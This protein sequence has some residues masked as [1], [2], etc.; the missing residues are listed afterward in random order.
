MFGLKSAPNVN[1][2]T[3]G[4]RVRNR[5]I[6]SLANGGAAWCYVISNMN[7]NRGQIKIKKQSRPQMLTQ[8]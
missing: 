4:D 6:V 7:N 1:I 8:V 2:E 3:H 5:L